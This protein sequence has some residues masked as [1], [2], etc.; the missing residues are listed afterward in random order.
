M[1]QEGARKDREDRSRVVYSFL[2]EEERLRTPFVAE[3]QDVLLFVDDACATSNHKTTG[4]PSSW[5]KAI[6]N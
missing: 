6:C 4:G 1:E 3:R 2:F 5:R